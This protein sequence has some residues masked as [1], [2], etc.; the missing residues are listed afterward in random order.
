M[1]REALEFSITKNKFMHQRINWKVYKLH[2]HFY[3]EINGLS[4]RDLFPKLLLGR[5]SGEAG[6]IPPKYRSP[7]GEEWSG[8]GH[9]PKWLT[10]LEGTG[11]QR[12]EFR[13]RAETSQEPIP[14]APTIEDI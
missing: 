1:Q 6:S 4:L 10:A 7:N 12:E 13:I 3:L 2:F 8:R 14:S 11:R 5:R 9:T